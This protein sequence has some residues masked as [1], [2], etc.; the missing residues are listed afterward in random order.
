MLSQ[1]V[2]TEMVLIFYARKLTEEINIMCCGSSTNRLDIE[3][4]V[5]HLLNQI[6][7]TVINKFL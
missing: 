3:I 7:L 2:L 4:N 6:K 1:R 5:P